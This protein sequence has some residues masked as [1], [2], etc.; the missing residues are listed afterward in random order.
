[1]QICGSGQNLY[2]GRSRYLPASSEDSIASL[3]DWSPQTV[4]GKK[5]NRSPMARASN[6]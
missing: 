3:Q 4:H 2:E 1:M 5:V 6:G